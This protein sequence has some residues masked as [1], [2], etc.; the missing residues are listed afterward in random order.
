MI[1]AVHIVHSAVELGRFVVVGSE[2]LSQLIQ[3]MQ[4]VENV[5]AKGEKRQSARPIE[6]RFGVDCAPSTE[7]AIIRVSIFQIL[8]APD[9][10]GFVRCQVEVTGEEHLAPRV[11]H[12]F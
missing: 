8:I 9:L 11:V 7:T 1:N 5:E 10:L 3:T 6:T 4:A 12:L 2:T